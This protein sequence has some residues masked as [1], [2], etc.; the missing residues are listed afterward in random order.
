MIIG[1]IATIRAIIARYSGDLA[2]SFSL[3]YQALDLFPETEVDW[4]A[5]AM[6]N[7]AYYFIVYLSPSPA[8]CKINPI[9]SCYE[10]IPGQ[11]FLTF[12]I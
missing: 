6:V 12:T 4:Q 11:A 3:A 8:T 7:A 2:Y 9:Y 5:S 10:R 1:Q